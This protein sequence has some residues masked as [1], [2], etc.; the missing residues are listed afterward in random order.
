[1]LRTSL[2]TLF[3]ALGASEATASCYVYQTTPPSCLLTPPEC[4]WVGRTEAERERYH[5]CMQRRADTL[6]RCHE[7]RDLQRQEYEAC[8]DRERE[9]A[10]DRAPHPVPS[11]THHDC[12]E[13]PGS[14]AQYECGAR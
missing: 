5:G 6:S 8:L 9:A 10:N 2:L 7:D 14:T 13:P 1:M 4:I 12:Y 11:P 3:A